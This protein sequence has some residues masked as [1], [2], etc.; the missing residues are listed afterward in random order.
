MYSCTLRACFS[1]EGLATHVPCEVGSLDVFIPATAFEEAV[2]LLFWDG[3]GGGA[4][5]GVD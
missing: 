1:S 2:T 4:R 3:V 5:K